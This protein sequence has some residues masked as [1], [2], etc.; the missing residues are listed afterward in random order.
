MYEQESLLGEGQLSCA[1][2]YNHVLAAC[3]LIPPVPYCIYP[4]IILN[5]VVKFHLSLNLSMHVTLTQSQH[6]VEILCLE[7]N[8]S[9]GHP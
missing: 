7:L 1:V 4:S 8:I 5:S 6:K 9:S 2:I 3:Q